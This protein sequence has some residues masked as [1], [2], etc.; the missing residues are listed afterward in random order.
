MIKPHGRQGKINMLLRQLF[1]AIDRTGEGNTAVVGWGRGMGHKGHMMLASSVITHAEQLGGDPYFVVSRTYGPDDP[2]QPEEKLAIYRKV[3]P[4]K[5]HIFQTATDELPDLTRVLTNLNGQGYKNAVVVVGADQK[6]AFQYLNAYNGK[7]NKKGEIPFNFDSLNVISRQETGDPSRG[8]E[9]PRATPMRAV[10]ADPGKSDEEQFAVWRDAM[11]P[12]LSDDEVMDLMQKAKARMGQMAAEKPVKKAKKAVAEI[13]LDEGPSLPSTLKSIAT[14]GEPIT[15]LYGKLKAMAKRWVDNNG[16]LKGFHRNAAGQSAQWFNNFYFNKLQNDLYALTKQAPKYAPPLIAFLKD[17]SEDRE[18]HINFTEISRSLPPILFQIGKRMGDESLARF[19]HSWKARKDE[20]DSYL[21]QLEAEADMD[22]EYD[23]PEVKPEKSK[24]P[25][26]QNAQVEQ[27]VNDILA[28][29]P[30]NV[31]GDIRNAIARA[32]NKL[33]ALQQELSKRKIQGVAEGLKQTLRKF[34]PTIKARILAKSQ[35]QTDQGLDTIAQLADMGLTSDDMISRAMKPNTYF[36]NAERYAKLLAKKGVAEGLQKINWVKPNFDFEW[37]EVEEQSRM[38]QVPVDVRQYYQKHFPNKD[39]W[40]KAVQNG[41]AVVVPPDHA[42]EIRNAPFDKAS[43][44]KVLAPTGHEGPIGPAKEKRVNDLFDKGQVE[45]PIILKTSQGLWLIGGKTRLGTANY[46][47]GLPAKVWLISG[48]QG[49]TEGSEQKPVIIYTNNRGAT[50]DDDIKKSLPVT[51]LPANKLQMWEKHKSMKDPK[52]ANW[53]TNKL[54]PELKQN[55]VLKPLLVW[56][57]DGEFF[58]IDGNHRFIAYQV[59]GYQGRVP[60]Q[61][62]PDNMVNISDTLP[63]Q[64]GVAESP[65]KFND[66]IMQPGFRWSEDINGITYLVRTRWDNM[67]EVVARVNNREVGRATFINHH[68]RSGLESVSTYVSPKWQGWGIAKNMYAVMR[69]LGANIQPS[70]TQTAMGKDMWAKWKKG[71]DTK[72]LTSM[73]AKMDE[74]GDLE[75]LKPDG[76]SDDYN[77]VQFRIDGKT[78]ERGSEDFDYYYKLVFRK[79]PPGG[80][81]DFVDTLKGM[82]DK[83]Y[84]SI[85]ADPMKDSENDVQ[86]GDVIIPS[87]PKPKGKWVKISDIAE[88]GSNAID[89][90][91]KRLTDPKDG[92]TAKLRAAGDK[93][94]EDKLKGRNISRRDTTSKDEWG[95][96]KQDMSETARMSAAAKLSKAWDQ[97]QAKSAASRKRGEELLNPK[98][99]EEPNF[100]DKDDKEEISKQGVAEV[101]LGNVL[102]WPEVVNKVNS[103]MKATGWKGKRMNDDA[104][105][106]TT[107]G[108][109]VEDQWYIAIIDN[110]GD[111][112]FT[113]ALGTVE[114]GDPHI[115]DAFKGRLPNTEASV[116]ELMN[117]IRDGFGLA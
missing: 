110:A 104:F 4:E 78:V 83:D 46:V 5:G 95:D 69:M 111:G 48:K 23:E 66:E 90:V 17:A 11:S 30:K 81:D 8:E 7:P 99:K 71:G 98:K 93:R 37:H 92:M 89:T 3:F 40:L 14:N 20:Y 38:K 6:A 80:K 12:E 86:N 77:S 54:L 45:M 113:Y 84:G 56:N 25:G 79:N 41:K 44:Q 61:I 43:L 82:M 64:Q 94:R 16:S 62:V 27:I 96:L 105:M 103:A 107:R 13:S 70:T 58:V 34:D 52:I 39:A 35:D 55:G 28:K 76:K 2:L 1:E 24:V 68:T 63:G 65:E 72:H 33:Q 29:L 108:A 67:P 57:N 74:Q 49:V 73:N 115:D 60:V 85:G 53:V 91:A 88:A 116:S 9:G 117:E 42:Y 31:A 18:R 59:A 51:E 97:Q 32:P 47:K 36:K 100:R 50:I 101:S 75:V 19:A 102:P 106:F 114:E 87:H 10:L 15:Q 109:E 22:D 21:S 112:F 26:Q